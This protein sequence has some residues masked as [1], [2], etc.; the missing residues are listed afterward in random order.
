MFKTSCQNLTKSQKLTN[1]AAQTATTFAGLEYDV[2]VVGSGMGGLAASIS[3]CKAGFRVVCIEPKR[4][5]HS[6][7]GESLDWSVPALLEK[8]GLSRDEL[9]E[10]EVATYKRG[11]KMF[12]FGEEVFTKILWPWIEYW[13]LRFER[14]TCHVDR[15][16]F[17]QKL[18]EIA[19][20]MGVRFIWERVSTVDTEQ[21]RVVACQTASGQRITATWFIDASGRARLFAKAF[22]IA[23]SEYGRQKVCLWTHF[24]SESHSEGTVF[25]VDNSLKYLSWIWE[26]PITPHKVSIGYIMP[27]DQLRERRKSGQS[28]RQ[29]L[30]EALRKHEGD[31]A[32]E[33]FTSLLAKQPDYQVSTCSYHTYVN[34]YACGPNWF[35]VG[36]AA[37]MPDPL[38]S[39]GVTAAIR[40]A[41]R[42]TDLIEKATEAGKLSTQQQQLYNTDVLQMGHAFNSNI[43][44]GLY[45]W[46]ARQQ[47]GPSYAAD[48]YIVFGYLVNALYSKFAPQS[49]LG[50]T[51]FRG[52]LIAM[53]LWICTF[54]LIAKLVFHSRRL[55]HRVA[56]SKSRMMPDSVLKKYQK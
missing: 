45:D 48:I 37:C 54:S 36:E 24:E 17:D 1:H 33:R 30:A 29:I 18:F 46:P 5:P 56:T 11:I 7:V 8:L 2:A 43:E 4:F 55:W 32:G 10:E 26:I 35:M 39:N 28:V 51:L 49:R 53:R 12:S 42:A 31:A 52:L 41:L 23:K 15:A 13:P 6:P 40:H 19:Q 20:K 27:A 16:K 9:V 14:F 47:F 21:D 25:H 22:D 44:T 38:T 34:Q 50:V 3:L